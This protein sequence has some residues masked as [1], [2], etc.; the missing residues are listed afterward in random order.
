MSPTH[1]MHAC[2]LKKLDEHAHVHCPSS[3]SPNT[4]RDKPPPIIQNQT[5][6]QQQIGTWSDPQWIGI[7]S[8][9]VIRSVQTIIWIMD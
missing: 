4:N 7:G 6:L 9:P 3:G 8:V 5:S 2:G 1:N